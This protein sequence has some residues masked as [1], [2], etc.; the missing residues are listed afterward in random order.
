VVV[1]DA[2]QP[3]IVMEL[4][5]GA[6]LAALLARTSGGLPP[7]EAV[8]LALKVSEVLAAAHEEG[9]VHRG[10]KPQNLCREADG[11]VRICDF[12]IA[13]TADSTTVS[14]HGSPTVAALSVTQ[15]PRLRSLATGAPS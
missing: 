12:G 2:G 8:D 1:Q 11:R 13:R 7:H 10:R 6:D 14:V 3:F 15:F 4:L 9:V 5:E